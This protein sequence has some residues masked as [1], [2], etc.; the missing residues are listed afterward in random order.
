MAT[1][2]NQIGLE[3]VFEDAN[4]QRGLDGYNSSISKATSNTESAGMDMEAIWNG[5]SKVG[6]IAFA[7]LAAG[8]AAVA[9]ELYLA[10]TAAMD[11]EEVFARMD[12][13]VGNLAERTGVTSDEVLELADAMSQVIP[14]DDEVITSAIAMGL[15]FDGVNEDNIQPLISAAADLAEWTGKDLPNSM[16][17][18]SLAISDPDK[19]M[20]LFRDANITL[21]DAQKEVL[22]GFK[23]TGDTAGATQF[24]LERLKEKGI[25]GLAEA[26]GDTAQGKL[27]LMQTALGNLQETLGE[28]LLEALSEVFVEI[29]EFANDPSTLTF[30]QDLGARIGEFANMVLENL[31][32][33]IE[34]VQMIST[35][36]SENKP[37]IIGILAAIGVAMAAFAI[38]VVVASAATIQAVL[39][40]IAIMAVVGLAVAVLV[41]AWEEDW[42]G[43]QTKVKD[44]WK[45]M[46]P[47]F[48]LLK[49]WLEVNIPKA[50]KILA[51]FWEDVLQPAIEDFVGFVA[52]NLLPILVKVVQWVGENLPKALKQASDYW[53]SVL[54][55]AIKAVSSF[56]SG[57]VFPIFQTLFTWLSNT[58]TAALKTLSNI[59]TNVLLPAIQ[60]VWGFIQNYVI[61]LFNALSNLFNAVVGLAVRI[62]AGIWQNV[63][64]PALSAV[65]SFISSNLMPIFTAVANVIN[66]T[67]K[68]ALEA[69]GNWL[70]DKAIALFTPFTNWLNN[71][72]LK[73]WDAVRD[74][75]DF[76]ISG[77][78][79]L[80]DAINSVELPD[81]MS[82][83]SAGPSSAMNSLTAG[84]QGVNEQLQTMSSL[85]VPSIQQQMSALASLRDAQGSSGAG[86]GSSISSSS[87]FSRT[88]MFG[89]N[90]NTPGPSGF[91][92]AMQGL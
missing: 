65:W 49:K 42:G 38:S 21:T 47:T 40:I 11:A 45:K 29:T 87:S 43:I 83:S 3:A 2:D 31:P 39:P 66:N 85:S 71:T 32:S 64:L 41:K 78:D 72:F 5:L 91:I 13:V 28:G 92:E 68:P 33:V 18:L 24:I 12:F 62:L 4:F 8:I 80:V 81:W 14:I 23:E 17:T 55:P 63:L 15:T 50:L 6:E 82:G 19:A 35:W 51:D 52:D 89:V 1:P 69:L 36:L 86:F 26:M 70:K 10:V 79:D 77:I 27:T 30:F 67:V 88:N 22:E 54:L 37:L 48:D 46:K 59:W 61:P 90:I 73:A 76:V 75:I 58:L 44:A 56:L 74:A 57:T 60:A 84:L 16:K 53:Q 25:L 7:A 34:G 20:R 9:A